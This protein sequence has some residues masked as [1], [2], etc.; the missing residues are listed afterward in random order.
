[1]N[2]PPIPTQSELF[3]KEPALTGDGPGLFGLGL[4]GS[5][6]SAAPTVAP[7]HELALRVIWLSGNERL[8]AREGAVQNSEAHRRLV[9]TCVQLH[10]CGICCQGAM[11]CDAA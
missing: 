9:C 8:G 6:P 7:T 3:A 11:R 2:V 10:L 1:M 4:L 5:L